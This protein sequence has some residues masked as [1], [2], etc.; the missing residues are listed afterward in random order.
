MQLADGKILRSASGDWGQMNIWNPLVKNYVMGYCAA[1]ARAFSENPYLVCY[2]YTA[3]PHPFASQPPGQYQYSGYN[4]SA[5]QAFRDSLKEKFG[6][7]KNLNH[8]WHSD[9]SSFSGIQPPGD[10]Y[11]QRS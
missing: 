3:E 4:P 6:S 11:M 9:Y 1:Q 10:Q 5:I 7:I 2:D 8:S